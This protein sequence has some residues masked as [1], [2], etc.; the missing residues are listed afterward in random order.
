MTVKEAIERLNEIEDK[1]MELVYESYNGWEDRI[2]V[3]LRS[4]REQDF[5][6]EPSGDLK[7]DEYGIGPDSPFYC[8]KRAVSLQ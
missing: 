7:Y 6:V 5:L 8:V 4:I 2:V 3:R 1:S